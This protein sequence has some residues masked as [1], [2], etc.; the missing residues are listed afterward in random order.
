MAATSTHIPDIPPEGNRGE[1]D[2]RREEDC[3]VHGMGMLSG[4]TGAQ[5]QTG[6]GEKNDGEKGDQREGD[7]GG[8]KRR[9]GWRGK[10]EKEMDDRMEEERRM[11]M[12]SRRGKG[13]R[14]TLMT[15]LRMKMK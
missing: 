12:E 3:G 1:E 8:E 4:R 5:E 15:L 11:V 13:R 9:A 6:G 14:R 7:S 2:E 10:K